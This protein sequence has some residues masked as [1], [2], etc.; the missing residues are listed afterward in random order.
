[1]ST[2]MVPIYFNRINWPYCEDREKEGVVLHVCILNKYY[3]SIHC[4][5]ASLHKVI[6]LYFFLGFFLLFVL[7]LSAENNCLQK[8]FYSILSYPILP[9]SILFNSILFYSILKRICAVLILDHTVGVLCRVRLKI[10]SSR[11]VPRRCNQMCLNKVLF[12]W[13]YQFV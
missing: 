5:S 4:Y 7:N 9:C 1:M 2:W 8:L 11:W 12:Q 6:L 3:I 10:I 13:S